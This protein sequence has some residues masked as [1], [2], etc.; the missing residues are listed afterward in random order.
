VQAYFLILDNI[1]R[2]HWLKI[3]LTKKISDVRST[4]LRVPLTTISTTIFF[5]P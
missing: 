2:R 1:V 3:S 4:T 5:I